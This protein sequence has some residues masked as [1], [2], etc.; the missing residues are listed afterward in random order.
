MLRRALRA[1]AVLIA[2]AALI[3]PVVVRD[4][5]RPPPLTIAVLDVEDLHH[6]EGLR[7]RLGTDYA[8]SVRVFDPASQAA[9]C[10]ANG[11]CVLVSRGA[12]PRRVTAGAAVVG[13][14]SVTRPERDVI[15][16]VDTPRLTHRDAGALMHVTLARP[17]PRVEVF[18][19]D[20]V[21]G[22][23][24]PGDALNVW[25]PW[26]PLDEGVRLLRVA[27][28]GDEEYVGVNVD[29]S[30]ADVLV[31]EPEPTWIGTFVRRAL[32]D[33]IRFLVRGRTRIAPPVVVS[34]GAAGALTAETI[35][36]AGV[37][38]VTAPQALRRAE[39]DLLERFVSRR[40]GTLIVVPDRRP[41]GPAL[42]L[43]PRVV[44]EHRAAEE[45]DLGLLRVR[46][47]LVFAPLV[48]ETALASLSDQP[49][50]VSRPL[51]RGRIVV[52]G[53]LDAWRFRDDTSNFATF[54]TSLVWEG[55]TAAGEPLNL[56]LDRVAVA[57]GEALRFEAELRTLGAPPTVS[58]AE[59]RMRCAGHDE[60]V[61]VWPGPRPGTF[62]GEWRAAGLGPCELELMVD[63]MVARRKMIV[64][65]LAQDVS[66]DKSLDAVLRAHGAPMVDAGNEVELVAHLGTLTSATRELRE[67]RPMRSWYWLPLFAA[68][69]GGELW[70]RRRAGLR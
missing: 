70:L 45:Q 26:V 53:A 5:T 1:I 56:T 31:Y 55:L 44:A 29:A 12:L 58:T 18:D 57:P 14:V 37:V 13:G 17:V 23:T 7:Q 40:G 63:E 43:L 9:A 47:W 59:G 34:Y 61:R 32:Q 16:S 49:I 4:A 42:R 15:A 67:S 21:V 68:C 41:G 24:E 8:A 62:E 50:V 65:E 69:L 27:A 3:D 54:W 33:D 64:S 20:V 35:A 22:A 25:V 39:L 46:E 2:L 51:G 11:A 6:G 60:V 28:D 30:A 48:G 19:G 66:G 38:V 10:P 36:P 52:S